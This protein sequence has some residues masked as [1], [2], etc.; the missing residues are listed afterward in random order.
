MNARRQIWRQI[1]GFIVRMHPTAF[2][3]EFGGEM[4]LDFEDAS[5]G[6]PFAPLCFDALLSVGRQWARRASPAGAEPAPVQPQ[7]LLAGHYVMVSLGRLTWFDLAR[8]TI[9]APLL[10]FALGFAATARN[11][12]S[13]IG[14]QATRTSQRG[15][16]GYASP[17]DGVVSANGAGSS[18]VGSDGLERW[19]RDTTVNQGTSREPTAV[20]HVWEW[21][22]LVVMFWLTMQLLLRRPSMWKKLVLAGLGYLAIAAPMCAQILHADGPLPS[23]EVATIRPWQPPPTPPAPDGVPTLPPVMFAPGTGGGQT[24]DRVQLTGQAAIL[25]ALAY[26]IPIGMEG[27]LIVGG[28][29]WVQAESDR[30]QLQAKIDEAQFAAMKGLPPAKQ[31]E[32]VALMEQ[33]LLAD[34]FKLKVHFEMREMP[35]YMLV[36]AKGGAKLTRAAEGEVSRL[37]RAGKGRGVEMTA[38]AVTMDQLAKCPFL[39]LRGGQISDQTGLV[40]AFDFTLD[41]TAAEAAQDGSDS[42][43]LLTAIQEQLGL[44]LVPSKA[45]VEVIVIDH[46]ERPS[47]N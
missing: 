10:L 43:P 46:I 23:F 44:K 18:A 30:Y 4:M 16:R 26:R 27:H 35:A 19:R 11:N 29:G 41:W 14:V 31:K 2:R 40:G 7:S 20:S 3:H 47:A 21:E 39:G 37:A 8:A 42:P 12:R 28:P 25:I 45:L 1:Y 32:Q 36:V 33:A 6:T 15:F 9:L 34:R 13:I 5:V 38:V 24:T 22:A 17:A